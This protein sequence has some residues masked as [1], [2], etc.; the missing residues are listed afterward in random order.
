MYEFLMN[1]LGRYALPAGGLIS[2]VPIMFANSCIGSSLLGRKGGMVS[3]L[4]AALLSTL[5]SPFPKQWIWIPFVVT[6]I[7]LPFLL[8]R[9]D[10]AKD[11]WSKA[12]LFGGVVLLLISL[13]LAVSYLWFGLLSNAEHQRL[14]AADMIVSALAFLVAWRRWTIISPR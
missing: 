10:P 13:V 1:V 4:L 7:A 6:G 11:S 5:A 12:D 9:S 8:R 14:A 2:L 3:Q